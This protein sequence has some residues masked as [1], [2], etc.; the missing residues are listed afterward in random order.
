MCR[1]SMLCPTWLLLCVF[2]SYLLRVA[3]STCYTQNGTETEFLVPCNATAEVSTCCRPDDLCLSNG[4]CVNNPPEGEDPSDYVLGGCTDPDS[5]N[6]CVSECAVDDTFDSPVVGIDICDASSTGLTICCYNPCC[7]NFLATFFTVPPQVSVFM[8]IPQSTHTSPVTSGE[9]VTSIPT[10]PETVTATA[11]ITHT[12][13]PTSTSASA[14]TP[15]PLTLGIGLGLGIPLGIALIA[16]SGLMWRRSRSGQD[17][18]QDPKPGAF[19]HI[20]EKLGIFGGG[21]T[22]YATT[23]TAHDQPVSSKPAEVPFPVGK[24]QPQSQSQLNFLPL[25]HPLEQQASQGPLSQHPHPHSSQVQHNQIHGPQELD[26][27]QSSAA[28]SIRTTAVSPAPSSP[29][30]TTWSP[31][32]RSTVPSGIFSPMSMTVVSSPSPGPGPG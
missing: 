11:T 12:V 30:P 19:S 17:Q 3:E 5:T 1:P 27:T 4:L 9:S 16:L 21:K 10:E 28:E 15:Q 14:S 26:G 18:N 22:S 31:S 6:L 23:N 2:I 25:P 24:T 13:S 32:P 29:Q 8:P 20:F 7:D